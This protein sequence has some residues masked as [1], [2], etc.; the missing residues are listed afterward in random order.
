MKDNYVLLSRGEDGT[1]VDPFTGSP[2]VEIEPGLWMDPVSRKLQDLEAKLMAEMV[3]RRPANRDY[4][5]PGPQ[6]RP[7]PNG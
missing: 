1:P 5:S 4:P 2:M 6:P 7:K 3:N